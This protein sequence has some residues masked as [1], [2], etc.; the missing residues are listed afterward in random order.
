MRKMTIKNP[1]LQKAAQQKKL[2]SV[3]ALILLLAIVGEIIVGGVMTVAQ[4]L[5]TLK[6]ACFIGLF[7]LCQLLVVSGG[8]NSLDLSIGY[9]AT[10]S[11]IFSVA[12]MD[13]QGGGRLVLAILTAV[14]VGALIGACNG[15]LIAWLDLSPL[16][17]TMSMSSVV[18]GYINVYAAGT[19]IAGKP[20]QALRTLAVQSTL[21]IP[22]LVLLMIVLIILVSVFYKRIRF[23]PVL[24]GIGAKHRTAFLSGANVKLHRFLT[25]VAS[26]AVAGLIGLVLAGNMNMAFKDMASSYVMPSYAAVV[27]GG[28]AL[29]GGEASYLRVYLGAV[30]L[31]LLTNLFIQFG[32]GDAVKWFGFGVILYVLLL[33][34]AND[35]RKK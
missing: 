35:R 2:L 10:L 32:G 6:F 9:T 4:A 11:A 25:F 17:V 16:V 31:Q 20:A 12:I 28:V 21:G 26:G 19:S 23:G 3:L 18:Q 13:G 8:G 27:V 24:L 5:S 33:F 15:A 7:A 14:G 1:L 34:Y 29:S 22:N 30:F